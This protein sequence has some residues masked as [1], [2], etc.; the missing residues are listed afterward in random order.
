[1]HYTQHR[2]GP[3]TAFGILTL[4]IILLFYTC[5]GRSQS[6]IDE[7][8]GRASGAR[9]D[10]QTGY[11]FDDMARYLAGFDLP[12]DS[13]LIPY[14]QTPEYAEHRRK[15]ARFW[16]RV[17]RQTIEPI[18][19]WRE[20]VLQRHPNG[21]VCRDDRPAIYP[22][23]GADIINL[24][25]FCPYANEYIMVALDKAGDIPHPE[26]QTKA[27]YRG[28]A[29]MRSVIDNIADRNYFFSAHLKANVNRNEEIPGIA[30]VLLAFSAGLGW[31]II[32]MEK[33]YLSPHGEVV[34]LQS[35][36]LDFKPRGVRIWFRTAGDERIRS[37]TY[38]EQ[39][40][41]AKSVSPDYPLAKYLKQKTGGF[42]MLK[43]AVY[44]MHSQHRNRAVSEFF[45][46]IPDVIVQDDSGFLYEDLKQN[47]EVSIYGEYHWPMLRISDDPKKSQQPDLVAL[48]RERKPQ[49]LPFHFGYGVLRRPPKSNLLVAHRKAG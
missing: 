33:I 24:Y 28:L 8:T 48:Y 16:E 35:P 36:Y 21:V 18:T 34:Q 46:T 47:F 14:T 22:L 15:M 44:L 30:P 45:I 31:R 39:Y 6:I 26:K 12:P 29:R 19:E 9:L 23:C 1:M 40:L 41:N 38:I 5:A 11:Y 7:K 17:R 13:N 49:P 3:L 32:D 27:Y 2:V 43:A 42:M 20:A 10:S 37:L 25:A 4:K